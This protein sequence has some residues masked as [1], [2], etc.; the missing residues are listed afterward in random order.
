MKHRHRYKIIGTF[1]WIHT[2]TGIHCG[3]C[4]D[5]V[6]NCGRSGTVYIDQ[7]YEKMVLNQ[8]VRNKFLRIP[9]VEDAVISRRL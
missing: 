1:P 4:A 3:I 8:A 9:K 5:I 7:K 6:C 2:F